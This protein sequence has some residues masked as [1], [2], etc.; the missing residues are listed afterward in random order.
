MF[1]TLPSWAQN[2]LLASVNQPIKLRWT[3]TIWSFL[4]TFGHLTGEKTEMN[5]DRILVIVARYVHSPSLNIIIMTTRCSTKKMLILQK[6]TKI[7]HFRPTSPSWN[8]LSV[9]WE[10]TYPVNLLLVARYPRMSALMLWRVSFKR[11]WFYKNKSGY[12]FFESNG[13][14]HIVQENFWIN[15]LWLSGRSLKQR[16]TIHTIYLMRQ[17]SSKNMHRSVVKGSC[18][19]YALSLSAHWKKARTSY[20]SPYTTVQE[21]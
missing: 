1:R 13:K 5:F 2:L 19:V 3:Y 14:I 21:E 20:V 9:K 6:M 15:P 17:S 8:C 18:H 4:T 12:F 16:L 10:Q 7:Q 11:C